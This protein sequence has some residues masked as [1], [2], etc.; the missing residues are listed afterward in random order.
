MAQHSPLTQRLLQHTSAK[1]Q[2]AVEVHDWPGARTAPVF[3]GMT[4]HMPSLQSSVAPH[5]GSATQAPCTHRAP[6]PHSR[7]PWQALHRPA[8]HT[9]P[10]SQSGVPQHSPALHRPP[11]HTCPAP[12]CADD[13]QAWHWCCRHTRPRQSPAPQQSPGTHAP[14]QHRALAPQSTSDVQRLQEWPWQAAPSGQSAS[15]QQSPAAHRPPQHRAP[16]PHSA[17]A[18]HAPQRP[19]TQASP[20]RHWRLSVHATAAAAAFTA[21]AAQRWSTHLRPSHCAALQQSPAAHCPSQHTRP[22]P[23]CTSAVHAPHA[24]VAVH[25]PAQQRCPSPHSPDTS[26]GRQPVEPHTCPSGHQPWDEPPGTHA[27]L[28]PDGGRHPAASSNASRRSAVTGD[29]SI[30]CTDELA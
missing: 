15:A 28:V 29:R 10:S 30:R 22:S 9:W 21:G 12:H 14:P 1:P 27:S 20:S 18:L 2:L 4:L 7:S 23:H 17:S 3:T 11:Q 25:A 26:H 5:A 19:P 8:R 13:S 16:S 6:T 24:V